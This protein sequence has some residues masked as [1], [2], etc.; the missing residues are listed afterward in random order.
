MPVLDRA[1]VPVAWESHGSG[2]PAVL[3][4][5][6]WSIVHSRMWKLQVP[7]LARHHRVI[8]FDGRGNGCSGRPSRSEDYADDEIVADALA[9]LDAAAVDAAV[10]VGLSR[11]VAWGL[12]LAAAQPERVLGLVTI[13]ATI[14]LSKLEH[15]VFDFFAELDTDD[16]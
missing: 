8:T 4:L 16:G 5:P 2:A 14:P 7:Y 12:R 1:G 11:G 9:V 6:A 13:S 3:L 10:V 15:P